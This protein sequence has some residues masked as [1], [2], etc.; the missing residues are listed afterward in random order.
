MDIGLHDAG[1]GRRIESLRAFRR[2]E[3]FVDLSIRRFVDSSICGFVDSLKCEGVELE[4]GLNYGLF[5]IPE[6][7]RL[8]RK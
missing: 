1:Q 4:T 2:A 5:G 6:A 8:T 7:P 3:V